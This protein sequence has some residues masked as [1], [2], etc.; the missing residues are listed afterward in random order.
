MNKIR[1]QVQL[2]GRLGQDPEIVNFDNG[3]KIAKF[4]LAVDDSYKTKEGEKVERTQW[5][6]IVVNGGLVNVVE[7]Y[8]KK[9][10]EIAIQGKLSTRSYE[11]K[12]GETRYTTEVI[13]YELLLL[14][15]GQKENTP[16]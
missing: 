4:S 16:Y 13:C 10:K 7:N 6:N 2:I 15:G 11:T 12:E 14:G 3:G 9:G 1:N 8:V 5:A